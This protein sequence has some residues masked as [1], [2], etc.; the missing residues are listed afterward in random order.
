MSLGLIGKKRGMTRRFTEA[1]EAIP[2]TVIEVTPNVVTQIKTQATDGYDAVQVTYGVRR[3]DRVTKAELGHFKKA[4]VPAGL[5]L[6]EFR[7]DAKKL[8]GDQ[9][10]KV[11]D[12]ITVDL[13]AVGEMVNVIGTSKGRGFAGV[14]KRWNFRT[15]D[16]THGNSLSH[17][18][19]GSTGQNQ[20]PGRTFPGKKMPGHYGHAR[21]TSKSLEVIYVDAERNLV[22]VKGAVPGPQGAEVTIL[23]AAVKA[24]VEK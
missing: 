7:V 6:S 3:A 22:L 9:A 12:Q 17:R 13:F 16:A 10:I 15:Q 18:V 11:G 2:V 24:K 19:V 8:A 1:G 20:S 4:N 14:V 5:G 23:S 21:V